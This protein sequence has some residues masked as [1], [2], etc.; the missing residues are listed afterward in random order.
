MILYIDETENAQ[1]FIVA[2]IIAK[3]DTDIELSYK[4]FKKSL[5]GLKLSDK[6]KARLFTEFKSTILDRSY[7]SIKLKMLK[8]ISTV[9]AEILCSIYKKKTPKLSQVQ[10]EAIYTTLFSNILGAL[11]SGTDIVFDRF[12]ISDFEERVS[13]LVSMYNNVSSITPGD[14]EI[15]HGLQFADNICSTLR[16]HVS[17]EDIFKFYVQIQ[18]MVLEV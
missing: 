1:F 17:N 12:G 11:E 9:D 4:Q 2:G 5:N 3:S 15:Y 14:S 6:A 13:G 10:K 7:Q 16:L 18:A 8:Q